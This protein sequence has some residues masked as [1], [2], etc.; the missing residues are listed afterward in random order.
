MGF[1]GIMKENGFSGRGERSR[2][3]KMTSYLEDQDD[4]GGASDLSTSTGDLGDNDH[5]NRDGV[6]ST[7]LHY[8]K[9]TEFHSLKEE[10][11]DSDPP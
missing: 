4:D 7:Q 5:T 3:A 8:D 10:L 6:V 2:F 11:I 1:T 9:T